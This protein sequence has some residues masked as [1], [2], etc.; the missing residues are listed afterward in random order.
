MKGI[1]LQCVSCQRTI[2]A[3]TAAAGRKFKCPACGTVQEVP[4][5]PDDEP[6]VDE[7][8]RPRPE[9]KPKEKRRVHARDPI[10]VAGW[11]KVRLGVLWLL[12]AAGAWLAFRTVHFLLAALAVVGLRVSGTGLVLGTLVPLGLKLLA[13]GALVLCTFVPLKGQGKRLAIGSLAVAVLGLALGLFFSFMTSPSDPPRS[14]GTARDPQ[15]ISRAL[16][17]TLSEM[18]RQLFWMQVEGHVTSVQWCLQALVFL[19]FLR[20]VARHFK[21]REEADW[22]LRITWVFSVCTILSIL[23]GVLV[24]STAETPSPEGPSAAWRAGLFLVGMVDWVLGVVVCAAVCW[25]LFVLHDFYRLL[26]AQ[27]KTTSP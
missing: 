18:D 17:D 5:P 23:L 27:L 2:R 13:P 6:G 11:R 26:G 14:V 22:C 12:V 25:F 21:A 10:R 19:L 24:L 3:G 9:R 4:S 15:A 1:L 8:R 7:E 20:T 16:E